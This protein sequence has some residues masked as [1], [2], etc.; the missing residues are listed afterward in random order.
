M[1][2]RIW[3]RRV[4]RLA[5]VVMTGAIAHAAPPPA[6]VVI[7][8]FTSQG[9][10]SCPPAD[11]LL[12]QLGSTGG[13]GPVIPL[14]FHVDYWDAIGW[15]D[16]FS[17]PA[18]SARQEQYARALRAG[19]LFTPQLVANGR[20]QCVG[21]QK[22]DVLRLIDLARHQPPAARVV[23]TLGSRTPDKL[24]IHASITLDR[25][26]GKA[27]LELWIAVTQSGLVTPVRG[28]ENARSTLHDDFVVRRLSK[29]TFVS[30]PAGSTA[31][32]D[33]V[34]ALDPAWSSASLAVVAFAQD[35]VSRA[36]E[37]AAVSTLR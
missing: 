10:E 15:K 5:V 2:Q 3:S 30:G 12:S 18:W 35:P 13:A 1:M 23:L 4:A 17:S 9:C 21:N 34:V 19:Q 37:G 8:L 36:I 6:P 14:A 27:P 31:Q 22:S 29:A 7:E 11:R 16:P 26:T 24:P 20:S 32:G 25:A 33:M 28:G